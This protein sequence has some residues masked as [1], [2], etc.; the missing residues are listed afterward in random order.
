MSATVEG[1]N[2]RTE[3][4]E[5][6]CELAETLGQAGADVFCVMIRVGCDLCLFCLGGGGGGG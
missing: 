1:A 5:S 3:V 6:A 4:C 2:T